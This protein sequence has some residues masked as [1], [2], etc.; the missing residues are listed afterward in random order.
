MAGAT[1]FILEE[2]KARTTT[3]SKSGG[4]GSCGFKASPAVLDS[5]TAEVLNK[6]ALFT[7][8]RVRL[9][10]AQHLFTS[11]KAPNPKPLNPKP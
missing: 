8:L 6:S 11:T 1:I 5:T 4:L 9:A 3:G 10:S 2:L 7:I